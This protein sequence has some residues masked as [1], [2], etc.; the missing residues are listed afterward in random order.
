M[1]DIHAPVTKAV[2]ALGAGAG[3]SVAAKIQEASQFMPQT[4]AE[5]LACVASVL[6]ICY[7]GALLWELR[8]KKRRRKTSL[9]YDISSAD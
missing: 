3:T 1:D 6:A 7:T 8:M 4:L 9:P 5:T 2:T